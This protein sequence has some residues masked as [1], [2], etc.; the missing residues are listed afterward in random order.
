MWQMLGAADVAADT[1]VLNGDLA[2]ADAADADSDDGS[3]TWQLLIGVTYMGASLIADS[4]LGNLQE[5]T[6][7]SHHCTPQ[8]LVFHNSVIGAAMLSVYT[9]LTGELRQAV[10]Y[11]RLQPVIFGRVLLLTFVGY[12]G[13]S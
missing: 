5:R 2:I 4:V 8:D 7:A 11:L 9:L 1:A 3:A 6:L 10:I 12:L 13:V